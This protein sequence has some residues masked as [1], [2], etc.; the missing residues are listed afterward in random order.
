MCE[1]KHS[2]CPSLSNHNVSDG[3]VGTLE[4]NLTNEFVMLF[5]MTCSSLLP[6]SS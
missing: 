2:L 4:V 6:L 1:V 3:L 5:Y